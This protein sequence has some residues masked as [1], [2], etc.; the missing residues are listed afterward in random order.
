[1]SSANIYATNVAS[2]NL[3]QNNWGGY[4]SVICGYGDNY[5]SVLTI[6]SLY[7][8]KNYGISSLLLSVTNVYT[9]STSY[10]TG[11][12]AVRFIIDPSSSTWGNGTNYNF[13]ATCTKAVNNGGFYTSAI[14]STT[15]GI[16]NI[17]NANRKR[18]TFD[19]TAYA[20]QMTDINGAFYFLA[21][22]FSIL[23]S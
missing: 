20:S 12:E 3:Q 19:L 17:E 5:R 18:Y 1:M 14:T 7:S 16:V 21:K 22:M 4:A 8:Y 11:A 10:S 6:P 9:S 23:W 2:G 15:P 13:D